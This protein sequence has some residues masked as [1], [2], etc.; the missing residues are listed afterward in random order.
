MFILVG[1]ERIGYQIL[2][3]VDMDQFIQVCVV[4]PEPAKPSKATGPVSGFF[5]KFTLGG[6]LGGF[7][8]M[9]SAAGDLP[10]HLVRDVPVLSDQ[11][12]LVVGHQGNDPG[13]AS[14][15]KDRI[16]PLLTSWR[17]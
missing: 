6:V 7:A 13:A 9:D 17:L 16:S 4:R 10:T 15:L 12:H 8:R 1:R 14:K 2:R 11:N 5:A 3:Q